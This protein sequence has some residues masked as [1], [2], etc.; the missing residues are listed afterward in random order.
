MVF[1]ITKEVKPLSYLPVDEWTHNAWS[2]HS[3]EQYSAVERNGGL[4]HA[5]Y[6]MMNLEHTR[7]E[8]SQACGLGF[9]YTSEIE[10]KSRFAVTRA[11]GDRRVMGIDSVMATWFLSGG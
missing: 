5:M 1:I 8:R 7:S 10:S 3:V 2:I 4:T 6:T 9:H 11:W